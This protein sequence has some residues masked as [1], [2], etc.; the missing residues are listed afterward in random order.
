MTLHQQGDDYPQL[1]EAVLA[2]VRKTLRE[3]W[4]P[5]GVARAHPTAYDEYD[6]YAPGLA[7]M[8]MHGVDF[9]V[10]SGRRHQLVQHMGLEGEAAETASAD[11][12]ELLRERAKDIADNFYE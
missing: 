9:E 4:D 3:D 11:I 7:T 8:L 1:Y 2:M 6:S 10:W 5:L 12:F